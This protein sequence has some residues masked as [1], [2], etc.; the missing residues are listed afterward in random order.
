MSPPNSD[1]TDARS[2]RAS[3]APDKAQPVFIAHD[4]SPSPNHA[5]TSVAGATRQSSSSPSNIVKPISKKNTKVPRKAKVEPKVGVVTRS[6]N[7]VFNDGEAEKSIAEAT[8]VVKT[9]LKS[10]SVE[11]ED[12]VS[13]ERRAPAPG[14]Q[15]KVKKTIAKKSSPKAKSEHLD[16]SAVLDELVLNEIFAKAEPAP[17]DVDVHEGVE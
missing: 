5:A 14:I 6:K 9:E 13:V 17:T 1:S 12:P 15:F 7:A 16:G 8:N 10:T 2:R 11:V 3:A 4:V